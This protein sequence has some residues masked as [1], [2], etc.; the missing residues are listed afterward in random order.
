MAAFKQRSNGKFE[1]FI[2]IAEFTCNSI[3]IHLIHHQG[4]FVAQTNRTLVNLNI[5]K[6]PKSLCG[7][8]SYFHELDNAYVE[9]VKF[10]YPTSVLN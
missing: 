9:L 3:S 7:C 6:I 10:H 8:C 1:M 5:K 2:N 4:R